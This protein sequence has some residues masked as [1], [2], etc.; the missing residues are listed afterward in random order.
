MLKLFLSNF[1][2]CLLKGS[3]LLKSVHLQ[4][5]SR[6]I[7]FNIIPDDIYTETSLH[8]SKGI[9]FS[10]VRFKIRFLLNFAIAYFNLPWKE[11]SFYEKFTRFSLRWKVFGKIEINA[12][13]IDLICWTSFA[14]SLFLFVSETFKI[15]IKAKLSVHACL[16][17]ILFSPKNG[18]K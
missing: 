1:L 15:I 2:G 3:R 4:F 8:L 13:I 17:F 18:W 9:A 16:N 11:K 7:V 10:S 12:H 5:N 14:V 6:S